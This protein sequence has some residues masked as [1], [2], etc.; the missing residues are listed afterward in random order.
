MRRKKTNNNK[1]KAHT[2]EKVERTELDKVNFKEIVCRYMLLFNKSKIRGICSGFVAFKHINSVKIQNYFGKWKSKC[3]YGKENQ[4]IPSYL[5]KWK[6]LTLRLRNSYMSKKCRNYELWIRFSK[7]IERKAFVSRVLSEQSENSTRSDL[8]ID[9]NSTGLSRSYNNSIHIYD[10][11]TEALRSVLRYFYFKWRYARMKKQMISQF[12][13]FRFNIKS[14]I[15]FDIDKFVPIFNVSSVSILSS[16]I[17]IRHDQ[18]KKKRISKENHYNFQEI[19]KTIGSIMDFSLDQALNSCFQSIN[20]PEQ[21][22][23][24]GFL[25]FDSIISN[26][27]QTNIE[28]LHNSLFSLCVSTREAHIEIP[29]N[30]S[31]ILTPFIDQALNWAIQNAQDFDFD[32]NHALPPVIEFDLETHGTFLNLMMN[33]IVSSSINN[34]VISDFQ[35]ISKKLKHFKPKNKHQLFNHV[36]PQKNPQKVYSGDFCLPFLESALIDTIM[37]NV[38]CSFSI[39]ITSIQQMPSLEPEIDIDITRI[40]SE[41]VSIQYKEFENVHIS[42]INRLQPDPIMF[43]GYSLKSSVIYRANEIFIQN[44]NNLFNFL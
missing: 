38:E 36:E 2:K 6:S 15:S 41:L 21:I 24:D 14:P 29:T 27:L 40:I 28:A 11:S 16:L 13:S 5:E 37:K 19:S 25:N 30:Y 1:D 39:D 17:K 35:F 23:I 7:S 43:F 3:D 18:E 12:P 10:D 44:I 33:E 31:H 42:D 9:S 8:F 34:L 22:D 32:I 4:K 26:L 20:S